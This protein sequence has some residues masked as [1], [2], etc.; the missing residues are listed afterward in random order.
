MTT[1]INGVDAVDIS[2][3]PDGRV[4]VTVSRDGEELAAPT[5][6]MADFLA[7]IPQQTGATP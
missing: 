3:E 5:F 6:S 7:A 4:R 1:L 2:T